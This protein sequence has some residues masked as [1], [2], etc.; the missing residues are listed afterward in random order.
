MAFEGLSCSDWGEDGY[1]KPCNHL[2]VIT[3][4]TKIDTNSS[5]H[6]STNL[7]KEKIKRCKERKQDH[8]EILYRRI[9]DEL[10]FACEDFLMQ[11]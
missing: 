9:S 10:I 8:F 1:H 4:E 6:V 7:A 5:K 3:F 11:I 2:N